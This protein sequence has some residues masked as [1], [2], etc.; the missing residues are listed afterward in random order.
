MNKKFVFILGMVLLISFAS[1]Q[2]G[3]FTGE[4]KS[5][6]FI[7]A[8]SSSYVNNQLYQPSFQTYYGESNRLGTYWPILNDRESCE[9]RQDLILQVAPGGCQPGVVRS[10]LLA[11]QNVPVFCQIDALNINPLLDVKE[12]RSI[13]FA[14]SYPKGVVAVGF[15]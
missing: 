14:N 12:I 8:K 1:A 2:S 11:E 6:S 13:S 15:H 10:D 5:G 7:G 9:A 3:S 4:A